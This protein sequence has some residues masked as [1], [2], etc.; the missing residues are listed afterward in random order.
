MCQKQLNHDWT[1]QDGLICKDVNTMDSTEI[2]PIAYADSQG[3][4]TGLV[5]VCLIPF[6]LIL[7]SSTPILSNI[8]SSTMRIMEVIIDWQFEIINYSQIA[9]ESMWL[10][11]L[12]GHRRKRLFAIVLIVH[13]PPELDA[14]HCEL[15]DKCCLVTSLKLP[16]TDV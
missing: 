3:W 6:H 12:Q 10:P 4:T 14:S 5:P 7:I 9:L 15:C 2:S 8:V 11:T 1:K 13:P 16:S